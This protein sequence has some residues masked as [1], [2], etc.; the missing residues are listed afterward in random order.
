MSRPNPIVTGGRI[1]SVLGGVRADWQLGGVDARSTVGV[2]G[3]IDAPA[4]SRFV[5]TTVDGRVTFP[6][7]H[8]QS[9]QL[10]THFVFTAG[11]ET[12]TQRYVAV[13]GSGTLSTLE[14]LEQPGD[15]LLFIDSRY[16]IPFTRPRLPLV[17]APVF[18]IRHVLAAAGV[19]SLPDLEQNIAVRLTLAILRVEVVVDPAR[20]RVKTGVALSFSR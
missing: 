13:G 19:R 17:G 20:D 6:T 9:F 3:A 8:T 14:I 2:E 16:H 11:D 7:F 12:P 15:Q 5:Q 4:S 10:E 18:T 1:T